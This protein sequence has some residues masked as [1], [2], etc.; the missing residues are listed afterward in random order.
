MQSLRIK[1]LKDNK[2]GKSTFADV[3]FV[4]EPAVYVL[5]H[6]IKIQSAL[7][8]VTKELET[9]L[10]SSARAV[11]NSRYETLTKELIDLEII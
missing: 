5:E 9:T 4:I 6:N 7:A 8:L 2:S 1:S 3:G 11:L 10:D